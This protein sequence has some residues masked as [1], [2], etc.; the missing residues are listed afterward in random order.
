M[1]YRLIISLLISVLIISCSSSE[2]T[3]EKEKII[4]L[5]TTGMIYDI[6]LNIGGEKVN[7]QYLMGPGVDPHLYKA[8]QNDLIKMRE[9]DVIFYN[10]LHLEGKMQETFEK[11]AK[12]KP[13]IAI[14]SGID[15]SLLKE[16]K[17]FGGTYDPHIW[18]D[19]SLWKNA[20][21]TVKN[22]LAEKDPEN[23][24]YYSK[25]ASKYLN[26][27]DELHSWVLNSIAT[28]PKDHRVMITAHDAFGYFGM[29]YDIEVRGLQGISTR[30]E[31]GLRDIT[32][33]TEFIT[34]N[35]IKAVFVES[36]VSEKSLRAVVEGCK[37]K[38][39]N[40]KIGGTLFS[41]AMGA[42]NTP[43]G[44]YDGMVRHNV[45]TIVNSLK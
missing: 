11:L 35:K 45:N 3:N 10:G 37:E 44:T 31:P 20:V 6:A 28:I 2:K 1:G 41:D 25:N 12:S 30:S 16:S 22:T 29:A 17:D 14:S 43:E 9:A 15:K 4:I 42:D 23:K 27:L 5:S 8:T 19:V 18:F 32:D 33:L 13:V 26:N 36:S 34:S 38:G 40:V 7:A 24:E 39:H 21:E